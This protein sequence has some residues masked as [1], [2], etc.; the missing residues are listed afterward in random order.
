MFLVEILILYS[1]KH[2]RV[3][4]QAVQ[5]LLIQSSILLWLAPLLIQ[6]DFLSLSPA[7]TWGATDKEKGTKGIGK[8]N[9]RVHKKKGKKRNPKKGVEDEEMEE[10][11]GGVL[12]D[13]RQRMK[14]GNLYRWGS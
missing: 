3:E 1:T 11:W 4:D 8:D 14:L 9:W 6:W 13:V 2:Y 10:K 7:I 12:Q 5:R